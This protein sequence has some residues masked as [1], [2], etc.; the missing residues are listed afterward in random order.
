MKEH[1]HARLHVAMHLTKADIDL[2]TESLREQF[3]GDLFEIVQDGDTDGMD[4]AI[5]HLGTAYVVEEGDNLTRDQIGRQI[6]FG[7]KHVT[8]IE[9]VTP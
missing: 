1:Q 3:P 8:I 2:I 4:V 7:D 6:L 5:E 9:P